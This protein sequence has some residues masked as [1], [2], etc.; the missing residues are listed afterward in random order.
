MDEIIWEWCKGLL[1]KEWEGEGKDMVI[2]V[3]SYYEDEVCFF[4]VI[5]GMSVDDNLGFMEKG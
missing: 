4:W 5:V 1:E 3:V 2:I